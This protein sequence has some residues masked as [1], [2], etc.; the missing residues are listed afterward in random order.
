MVVDKNILANVIAEGKDPEELAKEMIA[1]LNEAIIINKE[2]E[3][4]KKADEAKKAQLEAAG[5]L[6]AAFTSYV[7]EYCPNMKTEI[8]KD[9]EEMTPEDI[10]SIMDQ[11]DSSFGKSQEIIEKA[12][13][14]LNDLFTFFDPKD[15]IREAAGGPDEKP[16]KPAAGTSPKMPASLSKFL[17]ENGL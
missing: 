13:N 17:E 12:A 9:E 5:I 2:A 10:V 1:A 4:A 8:A 15:K 6:L 14:M 11:M 7:E 3:E 16:L